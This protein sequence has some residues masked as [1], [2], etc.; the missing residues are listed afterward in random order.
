M[1][2]GWVSSISQFASDSKIH[3]KNM[4]NYSSNLLVFL[5]RLILAIVANLFMTIMMIGIFA[6]GLLLVASVILLMYDFFFSN[7]SGENRSTEFISSISTFILESLSLV[8][9]YASNFLQSMSSN[10]FAQGIL[11]FT[12][13]ILFFNKL[14]NAGFKGYSEKWGTV[15][16]DMISRMIWAFEPIGFF[17]GSKDT[18]ED[19]SET[20]K[21]RE[22][23]NPEESDVPSL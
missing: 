7:S 18:T 20:D 23:L 8:T 3:F 4:F 13:L 11:F 9:K 15:Y 17:Q 21:M 10:L 19:K 16:R 2:N 5:I 22:R 6:F 12:V 14:I 1:R